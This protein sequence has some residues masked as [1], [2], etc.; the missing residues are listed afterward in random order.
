MERLLSMKMMET[1][2]NEWTIQK[3]KKSKSSHKLLLIQQEKQRS[4]EISIDF[5]FT[6][7]IQSDLNGMRFVV[8]ILRTTIL[9]LLLLGNKIHQR[10]DSVLYVV[11]LMSLMSA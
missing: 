6:I 4:L 1:A 8:N 10:L 11:Q 3:M 2:S 7:T 9:S 5:M